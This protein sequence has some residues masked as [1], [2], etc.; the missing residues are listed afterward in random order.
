M[1]LFNGVA[2]PLAMW[3]AFKKPMAEDILLRARNR[4]GPDS[5]RDYDEDIFNRA[6]LEVGNLLQAA[7]GTGTNCKGLG[8]FGLPVPAALPPHETVADEIARYDI[9]AQR[10][11]RDASVPAL[12][13]QQRAA[14]DGIMAA[15][16]SGRGEGIGAGQ[17]LFF[18]DGLGG[19]GKTFTYNAILSSVRAEGKVAIAVASSGIAALLLEGGRTAHSRFKIPVPC[20]ADSSCFVDR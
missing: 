9:T 17:S 19:A 11:K 3:E 6:L 2:D 1:L 10:E 16:A 18:L 7:S 8:T 13:Q 12:N 15:V 4:E 14:Y 5:T 20:T